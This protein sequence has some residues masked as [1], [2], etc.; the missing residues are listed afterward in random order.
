MIERGT[1]QIDNTGDMTGCDICI[2]MLDANTVNN[3]SLV[4]NSYFDIFYGG[5][6]SGTGSVT[7]NGL[8]ELILEAPNT[9]SGGT[10]VNKGTL[11]TAKTLPGNV[12]INVMGALG[13]F[14][15]AT[16]NPGVPGV[17]G[18]LSNAGTVF[19]HGGNGTV[20]GNYTQVST[21]TLAVKLGSKLDVT[22]VATLNGGTLEVT[23]ADNGYVSNAHTDVLTAGG[24]VSGTF[25]Q[26]VKDSGVVFTATTINYG[27]NDVWLDT[28]GLDITTAAAGAG[29]SY[30]PA[31]MGSAVRVQGAFE[32]LDAK[33]AAGDS[34]SVSGDFLRSAGAFQQSPNLRAAQ[35]SLESLSGELHAA[36]AAMTFEAIDASNRALSDRFDAL[37]DARATAG[38]WMHDLDVGGS[39]ARSGFDGI[40]VQLDGWMAGSDRRIGATGVAGFAFGQ[41]NGR[42][43]LDGRADR[44]R[45]RST[46]GMLYAGW[47]SGRRYVQGRVGF[48]HYRQ[49][50]SRQ[51]LLGSDYQGVGTDYNG[52]YDVAYG[53]SGLHFERGGTQLTPFVDLQYARIDR[54]AFAEQGAGGFGLRAHAQVLDR[55]QA[56][57]GV[58]AAHRW[59]FGGG[60][61]LDF[62][63]RVEWRRTLAAHGDVFD[64]SFVGIDQWQPLAGVGLSR[65]SAVFGLGLDAHLSDRTALTFG[66]D[67][68]RGDRAES[69][70]LVAR[71]AVAF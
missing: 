58:R 30:T 12:M 6:I 46:E 62:S 27:T 60:R 50:V 68:G 19:V 25:D 53:E 35:A 52:R 7:Q 41:S 57:F 32:Q 22:G 4:F 70:T 16:P 56:G 11:L 26:L 24:G 55:W 5:I 23:G 21:G 17:A 54:D 42:Q 38:M 71:L 65:R 3:G 47:S 33:I 1:L 8:D 14:N 28:T 64:A 34:D 29:V 10:T 49:D 9:Y 18:N 15:G 61:S 59:D 67:Y 20:G 31:S 51:L 66:Y 63:A 13:G 40:G 2:T 69:N 39:M 37:L 44:N 43:Q 45:S 36:S 48:G